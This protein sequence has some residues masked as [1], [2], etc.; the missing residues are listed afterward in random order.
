M[1]GREFDHLPLLRRLNLAT[2]VQSDSD[3]EVDCTDDKMEDVLAM[4]NEIYTTDWPSNLEH[5][6]TIEREDA[7]CNIGIEQTK[8]KK[9]Y[10]KKVQTTK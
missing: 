3:E 7:Q 4:D 10:D 8:Q 5:A 6:R 1:F 9:S 2:D